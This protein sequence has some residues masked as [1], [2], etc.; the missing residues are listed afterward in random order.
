MN[1]QATN[2]ETIRDYYDSKLLT[3]G[4]TPQGVDWNGQQSQECR[5]QQLSKIFP[6][7]HLANSSILDY[8]CGYAAYLNYLESAHSAYEYIG[9]DISEEMITQ[10]RSSHQEKQNVSFQ[11]G[12]EITSNVSYIVASGVFNVKL[13]SNDNDW[14]AYIYQTLDMFDKFSDKGF[15]FNCLTSFSD[16]DKMQEHLFYANPMSLFEWCKTRYSR[17]IA[18]LHDYDLYEFTILVRK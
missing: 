12:A 14:L 7:T 13:K 6:A 5:F 8:G 17:N 18:L 4:A 10:A 16:H 15:S 2:I 1:K 9:L 11:I 3:H